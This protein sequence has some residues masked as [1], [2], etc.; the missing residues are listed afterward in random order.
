MGTKTLLRSGRHCVFNNKIHL[1]FLPK[2]RR[3]VLTNVILVRLEELFR[4][5]CTQMDCE[6]IEFNGEPDHIQGWEQRGSEDH[7]EI[8]RMFDMVIFADIPERP[9]D[10][11]IFLICDSQGE[12]YS[13]GRLYEQS[14]SKYLNLSLLISSPDLNKRG[15]GKAAIKHIMRQCILKNKEGINLFALPGAYGFYTRMGFT[16]LPSDWENGDGVA[17]GLTIDRSGI[18]KILELDQDPKHPATNKIKSEQ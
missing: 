14:E 17:G 12:I 16:P 18:L 4:E 9:L 3:N 6:L 11:N 1:V 10:S 7:A 15:G 5:T 13:I 2:Y 8:A